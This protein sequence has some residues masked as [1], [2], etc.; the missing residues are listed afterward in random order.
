M[1]T[2][3]LVGRGRWGR[4]YI[5][6]IKTL[7]S[8]KLPDK[9]I[10]TTDYKHLLIE[11]NI[12]GVIIATPASTHFQISKEF[13]EKGFNILIEKPMTTNYKDA[14]E[15]FKLARSKKN[16]V[17]VGHIY[18]YNPAFLE[19]KRIF[20]YLGKI[21]YI[22][23]EGMDYGPIRAD[24]SA[25]WD[26][27]PH[28]ISMAIDL[29]GSLPVEVCGYGLSALRPNT[30][31]YDMCSLKLKFPKD[32]FVFINVSWLSR[33][34]KRNMVIVGEKATLVFDDTK[35][36]KII[37]IN[38]LGNKKTYYP[39]FSNKSPLTMEIVSF[40]DLIKNKG[41]TKSFS[42]K[43]GLDVVRVLEACD[44]SIQAHGKTIKID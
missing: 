11:K 26:W 21:K 14:L 43:M 25:L 32:I 2:L 7:S 18:L 31:Y 17:M 35:K 23:F 3:A 42:L 37:L 41:R 9:F 29:L 15:L 10:K 16:I 27:A 5:N 28:D 22:T 1:I 6:T 13:L 39:S 33:V 8:C 44:K 38:N 24:I 4:N 34:K 12:D 30:K 20:N 36:K 40:V 19:V